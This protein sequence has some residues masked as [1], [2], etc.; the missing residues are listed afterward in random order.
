MGPLSHPGPVV[1]LCRGAGTSEQRRPGLLKL[2]C[3]LFMRIYYATLC[4]EHLVGLGVTRQ[5]VP[6][7]RGA[8]SMPFLLMETYVLGV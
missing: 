5:T 1:L 4:A 6:V 3:S 8:K 7:L 2:A